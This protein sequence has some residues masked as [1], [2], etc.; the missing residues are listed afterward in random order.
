[1]LLDSNGSTEYQ[2]LLNNHTWTLV[3]FHPSMN[4]VGFKWV[5][6]LKLKADRTI[7]RYKAR[8]VAKDYN[9]RS[10][11][12]FTETFSLVV[13][14]GTVRLI[15]S[16]VVCLGWPLRQLDVTNAFLHGDL[17]EVVYLQQLV[18]FV[19]PQRSTHVCRLHKAL[20]G[21]KQTPRA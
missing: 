12:D 18:G 19:D 1:M 13:K 17:N 10:R 16:L 8:L 9:L 3:P 11:C 4:V 20:Y 2:A 5:Y 21:L 14:H 7:E 15:L 6:Q